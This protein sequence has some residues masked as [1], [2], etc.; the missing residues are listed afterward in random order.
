MHDAVIKADNKISSTTAT[1]LENLEDF[2][3]HQYSIQKCPWGMRY[4]WPATGKYRKDLSALIYAV[5][6]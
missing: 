5:I 6:S 2:Y 3:F 1:V 4:A